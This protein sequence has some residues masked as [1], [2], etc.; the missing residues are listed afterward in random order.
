MDTELGLSLYL[1]FSILH[2]MLCG[3]NFERAGT[4]HDCLIVNSVFNRAESVSNGVFSLRNRVVIR[5]FDKNS[6]GE[7]VFN[8]VDESVLVVSEGL[9][10]DLVGPAEVTLLDVID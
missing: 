5:P 1:C 3:S 7:G 2:Q 9:L 10:V 6:A 4:G 8:T